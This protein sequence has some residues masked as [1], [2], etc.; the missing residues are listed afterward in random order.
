MSLEIWKPIKGF[1]RYSVSSWGRVFDNKKHMMVRQE[2]HDKGYLRVDLIKDKKRTHKKV[3]RLV[4]EAFIPNP[5]GKPQVNHIDGNK[6]NNS[7]TN[8]EW[9]TDAE[10]KAAAIALMFTPTVYEIAKRLSCTDCMSQYNN[11]EG[12]D[13]ACERCPKEE[14]ER[15][16]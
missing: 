5:E 7:I 16:I 1:E 6:Q 3:H 14:G 11:A 8:L 12:L 15:E 13:E 4:A 10:N 2:V 9:V